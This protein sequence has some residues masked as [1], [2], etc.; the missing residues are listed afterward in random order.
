MRLPTFGHAPTVT[1]TSPRCG[2]ICVT[3][4]PTE[5]GGIPM[6]VLPGLARAV[7]S[8]K[9]AERI[10]DDLGAM[11]SEDGIVWADEIDWRDVL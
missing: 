2:P 11:L 4:Q 9:E 3:V 1:A 5:S 10:R 8:R 6:V 7:L